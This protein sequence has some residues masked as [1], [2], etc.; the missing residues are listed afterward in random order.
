VGANLRGSLLLVNAIAPQMIA[1]KDGSIIFMSS[2]GAKRGSAMLG[3]YS[4]SKA[5]I[6]QY[7]RNLA[8]ELGPSGV[9]VNSINPGPVRTEFSKV[10]LWSDPEKEAKLASTIPMRRLGSAEDVAGLAVLLCAPSGRFI[11]GQNISVDGGLTA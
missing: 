11:H 8:L 2:R 6:D 9:N 1:R 4:M 3:L 10:A 7:V 5:A